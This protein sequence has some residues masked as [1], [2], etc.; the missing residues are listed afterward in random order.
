MN[1]ENYE[2]AIDVLDQALVMVGGKKDLKLNILALL[3]KSYYE[4]GDYDESTEAYDNALLISP[5]DE[6]ILNDYGY[7]LAQRGE[8]LTE[9]DKMVDK[10]LAKSANNP[11]FLATK[12]WIAYRMQHL[13]EAKVL[14]EKSLKNGGDKYGYILEKYGD[15]LYKVDQK[16]KAIK[17][18]SQARDLGKGSKWLDKKIEEEKLIE[19][20]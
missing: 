16:D 7:S 20:Q 17:Y 19:Q 6:R 14:I 18:W 10:A 4:N 11:R 9:A 3:A 2:D 15:V 13:D 12:G 8:R 5:G 1:L